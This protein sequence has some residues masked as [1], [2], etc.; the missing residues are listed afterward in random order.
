MAEFGVRAAGAELRPS[1]FAVVDF[2]GH[3]WSTQLTRLCAAL[4]ILHA[5]EWC[6]H[7]DGGRLGF[8]GWAGGW[9]ARRERESCDRN[10]CNL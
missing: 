1:C 5:R 10:R 8:C 9:C 6:R 2:A 4:E 7:I 3:G